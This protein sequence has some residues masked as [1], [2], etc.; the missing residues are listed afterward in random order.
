MSTPASTAEFLP[1]ALWY[2]RLFTGTWQAG[3]AASSAVVEPGRNTLCLCDDTWKV[4]KAP[5]A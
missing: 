5:A 1:N 2:Q 3:N 4:C